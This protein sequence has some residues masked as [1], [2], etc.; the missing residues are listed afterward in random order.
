MS[1]NRPL[2]PVGDARGNDNSDDDQAEKNF[3]NKT[4]AQE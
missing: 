4:H 3:F 2:R 1:H